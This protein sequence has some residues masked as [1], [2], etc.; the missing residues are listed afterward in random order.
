MVL[1]K[2]LLTLKELQVEA[3]VEKV[4]LLQLNVHLWVSV[5]ILMELSDL[6][7]H[8]AVSMDSSPLLTVL[9]IKGRYYQHPILVSHRLQSIQAWVQL[10]QV[11]TM[12][13]L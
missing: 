1:L 5:L 11:S 6:L 9:P 7:P 4:V 13:K 2:I 8:F 3:L 10:L 12:S